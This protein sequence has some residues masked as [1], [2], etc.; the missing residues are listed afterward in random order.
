MNRTKNSNGQ[1][2]SFNKKNYKNSKNNNKSNLNFNKNSNNNN[3]KYN[4]KHDKDSDDDNKYSNNKTN[5]NSKTNPNKP[6]QNYFKNKKIREE[7]SKQKTNSYS[8]NNSKK[9]QIFRKR[10]DEI[11]GRNTFN[12][13]LESKIQLRNNQFIRVNL[14][15][16]TIEK[17]EEFLKKNR[18]KFSKTFI[19]NAIKIEKSF[20]NLT[21]SL[22]ALSGNIYFQ[23]LASQIPINTIN[24]D[25]LKKQKYSKENPIQVLDMAASPGSKTTQIADLLLYYKIPYEIT[26]LEF[27]KTRINRLINNIQK[28][29][30][31]NIS[32]INI[33]A[34]Q[35]K[36]NKKFDII[37]LDAPCS[38]NLIDDDNWIEKRDL[39]GIEQNAALQKKLIKN[40]KNLLKENG[41]IIYSTCSIEPEENEINI[42]WVK[43]KL[44]LK[45]IDSKANLKLNFKTDPLN[46]YKT[47]EFKDTNSIRIMPF[48]SKT[49]GFFISN[50]KLNK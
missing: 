17:I 5:N 15:K 35:F 33:D 43:K 4:K 24:F 32:I 39:M 14:S 40:A 21:S 1:K 50:L 41:I 28:Q 36:S 23:D 26:A 11:F 19:P 3:N 12:K 20:F 7:K 16:T 44:N 2:S 48:Y 37:I 25:E 30:L 31:E 34:S 10:Y 49:Q 8:T 42:E 6:N 13:L 45:T 38:G 47:E 46:K 22:P 27:E 18:V 9:S 29:E